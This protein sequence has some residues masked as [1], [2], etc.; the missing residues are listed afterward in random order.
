LQHQKRK[1]VKTLTQQLLTLAMV[2]LL[3][4]SGW[5]GNGE[6]EP[7]SVTKVTAKSSSVTREVMRAVSYPNQLKAVNEQEIVLVSFRAEACGM[8]TVVESNA[9]NKEFEAYVLKRLS[10]LRITSGDGAL[11]HV[12]FTFKSMDSSR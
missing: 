12:R 4:T 1:T 10:T 8:L 3:S 7:D 9:S 2:I 11:H 5:A 6:T